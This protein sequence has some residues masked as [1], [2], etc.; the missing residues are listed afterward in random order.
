VPPDPRCFAIR[1]PTPGTS[2]QAWISLAVPGRLARS[3]VAEGPGTPNGVRDQTARNQLLLA[4]LQLPSCQNRGEGLLFLLICFECLALFLLWWGGF[5]I[6]LGK[7]PARR[8]W[9][10]VERQ[11]RH[12]WVLNELEQRPWWWL[13]LSGLA[14]IVLADWFMNKWEQRPW[15]VAMLW[16]TMMIVVLAVVVALTVHFDWGLKPV[17]V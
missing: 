1:S 17:K 8:N 4:Y 2:W 5:V 3:L 12:D 6:A 9:D 10:R 13:M 15:R 16:T 14:M 11:R 7:Q